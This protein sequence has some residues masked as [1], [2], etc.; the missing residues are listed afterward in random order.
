MEPRVSEE[1]ELADEAAP[2]KETALAEGTAPPDET[3]R[4]PEPES[5][6]PT[7]MP[8][9]E[10]YGDDWDA[11]DRDYDAFVT[12]EYEKAFGDAE[13]VGIAYCENCD[14]AFEFPDSFSEGD[15]CIYCQ[16]PVAEVIRHEDIE[17]LVVGIGVGFYIFK[18]IVRLT[19]LAVVGY[20]INKA[21]GAFGGS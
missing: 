18:W 4:A 12:A 13:P 1:V 11:F 20:L 15:S 6:V 21:F 7:R 10:D 5:P 8:N 2:P 3:D 17:N 14:E 9:P 19:L 16:A